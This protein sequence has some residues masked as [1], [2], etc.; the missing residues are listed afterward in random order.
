MPI[1]VQKFGGSS[2]ADCD[3]I[4]AAARKAIRAQNEGNQVV[5]VLSAMGDETDRLVQLARQIAEEP[6]ARE[7]DM[8]LSTGEQV[9]VSLMAMAIQSLRHKAV[10]MTGAQMGIRTDSIH[11][12][13]RI[14]SIATD[15]IREALDAGYIVIAA[16]FQ[17]IDE[18]GNITT[19][20]RGG[21][22]TTA[23]ALA[24][25]L[26]AALCEIYT[27]VDGIYTTDPRIIPEARLLRQISY[28]EML[29]LASAGAGVMHNRSIEFAKKFN[30]PV[31]VRNSFSDAPGTMIVGD[32]ETPGAG[33]RRGA[34]QE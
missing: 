25:V 12:K 17:G 21:S 31:H 15:R 9:T 13:A 26:E 27:D 16:G 7:M 18:A 10:S 4:L 32:P 19:L 34:G 22:D 30:V 8:L 1:I 6:P 11:T 20:G 23:V 14:R 3:K 29:E 5:M 33:L 2:V 24:A 28:D